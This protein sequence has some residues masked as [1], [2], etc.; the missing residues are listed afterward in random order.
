MNPEGLLV[1][2]MQKTKNYDIPFN[3]E[4]KSQ[5][6]ERLFKMVKY[7][8]ESH[9]FKEII[10]TTVNEI[11][12]DKE[13]NTVNWFTQLFLLTKRG[14]LNEFRNPMDL[15]TRFITTIIMAFVCVIVFEGVFHNYYFLKYFLL[16]MIS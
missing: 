6:K 8:K 2:N 3:L 5:F 14:Y 9:D 10:P 13:I 4:I 12:N 15:R 7:Y 11:H 16:Q 1:E